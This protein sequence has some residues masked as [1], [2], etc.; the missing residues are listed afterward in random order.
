MNNGIIITILG[1]AAA[2]Y[3]TRFPLMIFSG[4]K[5]PPWLIR[6]M[7]FIAPAILTALIVPMVFIKQGRFDVSLSNNYFIAAIITAIVS[8][9]SKNMLASLIAG[10]CS[11]ALLA[12]I[13]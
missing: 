8:Y 1:A 3:L 2:T 11:V 6:Y 9:F 5:I 12:L 4:K 7:S 10:I 13:F